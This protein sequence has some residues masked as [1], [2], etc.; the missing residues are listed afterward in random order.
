MAVESAVGSIVLSRSRSSWTNV[1]LV[2]VHANTFRARREPGGK[3]RTKNPPPPSTRP[4]FSHSMKIDKFDVSLGHLCSYVSCQRE[5]FYFRA[6]LSTNFHPVLTM[7]ETCAR[8]LLFFFFLSNLEKDFTNRRIYF[9]NRV[10]ARTQSSLFWRKIIFS[11]RVMVH[12]QQYDNNKIVVLALVLNI[13]IF[14]N[15]LIFWY[16]IIFKY[17]D[18]LIFNNILMSAL[19]ANIVIQLKLKFKWNSH[20]SYFY[21]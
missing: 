12:W 19:R 10:S 9:S 16:L 14:N 2:A 1:N 3:F 13:L 6:Q 7:A 8:R 18:I 15:I 5:L 4:A 21:V 17:F 20:E 11:R